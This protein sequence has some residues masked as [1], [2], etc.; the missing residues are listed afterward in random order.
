MDRETVAPGSTLS[1][2]AVSE[3]ATACTV[4]VVWAKK[5]LVE[6]RAVTW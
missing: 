4:N 1:G 6:P 3:A 5:L 2:V